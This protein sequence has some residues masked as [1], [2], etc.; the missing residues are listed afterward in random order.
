MGDLLSPLDSIKPYVYKA[1]NRS[2]SQ[3]YYG[4]RCAN[5]SSDTKICDDLGKI[6]FSSSKQILENKDDF[7]FSVIVVCDSKEYAY[8]IEQKLILSEWGNQLLLNKSCFA[9]KNRFRCDGHTT[10]T[11]DKISKTTTGV[12]KSESTKLKMKDAVARR[13][14]SHYENAGKAKKGPFS[15]ERKISH[16]IACT[17][18]L[19][20]KHMIGRRWFTDG[21]NNVQCIPE[22]CP[23]GYYPGRTNVNKH[24]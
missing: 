15:D 24:K 20:G 14:K 22:N 21:I 1:T 9:N 5:V 16:S 6:Y 3:F 12:N 7:D 13:P 11:K 19:S 10:E 17:N 2:T 23:D 4:Y 18:G 8:D